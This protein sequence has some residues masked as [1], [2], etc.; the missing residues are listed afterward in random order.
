MGNP[1]AV[2]NVAAVAARWPAGSA[3]QRAPAF[4]QSV[5]VGLVEVVARDRIRLRVFERGAGETL[6]CGSGACAAVAVLVQ[7]GHVEADREVAV[8]LPGGTLRIRYDQ[9]TGH[10][11][12]GGPAAFVFE[13][14]LSEGTRL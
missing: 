5:N 11:R 8:E 1:H 3:L 2:I 6:A 12:M 7:G 13:G 9:A 10:V 14:T 4:P